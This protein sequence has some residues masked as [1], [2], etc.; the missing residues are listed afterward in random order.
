LGVKSSPPLSGKLPREA[1][2]ISNGTGLEQELGPTTRKIP[3]IQK[4]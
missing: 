2:S 3:E 4:S 1:G